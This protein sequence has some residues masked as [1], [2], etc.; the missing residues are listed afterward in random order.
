MN[1]KR[2][3][4][5]KLWK[6]WLHRLLKNRRAKKQLRLHRQLK[7][8]K[9]KNQL[10]NQ[11]PGRTKESLDDFPLADSKV[12][13]ELR[14]A[15]AKAQKTAEIIQAM[16]EELAVLARKEKM[17][18][19]DAQMIER[20]QAELMDKLSEF[21]QITTQVQRLVGL[22]DI[23][24][25]MIVD[26]KAAEHRLA[27]AQPAPEESLPKVI[28][29]GGG[30]IDPIPKIIVCEPTNRRECGQPLYQQLSGRTSRRECSPRG[31]WYEN[32]KWWLR[33][34]TSTCTF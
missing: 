31:R 25:K 2:R 27:T 14:E 6:M 16:K 5:H 28:I 13:A 12:M 23:T 22:T 19:E 21:E 18:T 20:K 11:K 10:K 8:R 9:Q 15:D 4:R 34:A 7:P 32:W 29:C 24:S 33:P 17:T 3:Q 30:S 26:Q 1:Q